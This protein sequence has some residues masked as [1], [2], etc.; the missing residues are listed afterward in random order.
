MRNWYTTSIV[1]SATRP[2]LT[3]EGGSNAERLYAAYMESPVAGVDIK[4]EDYT[5]DEVELV[6]IEADV[7]GEGK[8]SAAM[9]RLVGLASEMSIPLVLI[10]AGI[11]GEEHWERLIEF[12]S[13]FGFEES[14]EMMRRSAGV[15][16][17]TVRTAAE[18]MPASQF[19]QWFSDSKVVGDDGKPLVVY[20]GFHGGDETPDITRFKTRRNRRKNK[21]GAYFTDNPEVAKDF[22]NKMQKL[23][24]S[25]RN[26]LDLSR[27]K[28]GWS[29][30]FLRAIPGIRER[31][32]FETLSVTRSRSPFTTLEFL[33]RRF[34][35]VPRLK[36]LGYDGIIFY[37]IGRVADGKT[38]VAFYPR[39]IKSV[40]KNVG[41]Y[42]PENPDV[43]ASSRQW[44]RTSQATFK[45]YHGTDKV[46]DPAAIMEHRPAYV[47][48]GDIGKGIYFGESPETARS[49][50]RNVY[51][52]EVRLSKPLVI[53]PAEQTNYRIAP[54]AAGL[55][56]RT[57]GYDSVLIGESIIP[58]DALIGGE[59]YEV[60]DEHSLS[61]L[62]AVARAAGHDAVIFRNVRERSSLNEEVLVFD[63]SS[64]ISISKVATPMDRTASS[65]ASARV[66]YHGSP[67]KFD[68][69]RIGP[70]GAV[71]LHVGKDWAAQYIS[72]E[73]THDPKEAEL[74]GKVDGW[75]ATVR[76]DVAK[77]WDYEDAV[78]L[79]YAMRE[80][81]RLRRFEPWMVEELRAGD[82]EI[83]EFPEIQRHLRAAGFDS[84][85][86]NDHPGKCL[87]VFDPSRLAI[88][89]WEPANRKKPFGDWNE[90]M[91]KSD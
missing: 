58:F 32:I 49:Y 6:N 51:E 47:Y 75:V 55:Y 56:E 35:I 9:T 25:M 50:G 26:P 30:E 19:Q 77:T 33:D 82:W 41:A 17:R 10:P 57:G 68:K 44:F 71:F 36:R 28:D 70:R 21:L 52:A 5:D 40:D 81:R 53:D 29:E 63:K 42:D 88:V 87:G 60:R 12:Y 4:L 34:H 31:E 79:N 27:F 54:S 67:T 14:G 43:T 69:F 2:W 78:E 13:R 37:E 48:G 20:H 59:W 39:Q 65:A 91:Q 23:Y 22:G 62:G 38:F 7:K 8:G 16:R 83:L 46:F 89:S 61:G 74:E 76:A 72:G 90:S 15:A 85:Y 1:R 64:I 66:W 73:K 84:F 45:L 80:L 11:P 86:L 3:A 24:L 18:A